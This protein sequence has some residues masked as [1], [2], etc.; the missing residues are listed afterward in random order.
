VLPVEDDIV[1]RERL[2][3]VPADTTLELP[4]DR[5]AVAGHAAVL[6]R[7]DLLG[8]DR[9]EIALGVERGERLVEHARAVL[10]LWS[11]RAVR[12]EQGRR[13]PPE[14]LELPAAAA[15][16]RCEPVSLRLRRNA[17]GSQHPGG[18]GRAEAEAH[19][20]PGESAA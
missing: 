1:G 11:A 2:S 16:G 15:A 19:H 9:E 14:H 7:R 4:G 12:I 5:L 3:V 20:D 18:E 8:E 13:L 17:G 10:V 6:E